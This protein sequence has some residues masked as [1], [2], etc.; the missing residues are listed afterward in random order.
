MITTGAYTV[1]Q[2]ASSSIEDAQSYATNIQFLNCLDNAS[3]SAT[4]YSQYKQLQDYED[5]SNK[6]AAPQ[7]QQ[8]IFESFNP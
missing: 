8:L 6:K 2:P 3:I 5:V 7:T 1:E 4:N